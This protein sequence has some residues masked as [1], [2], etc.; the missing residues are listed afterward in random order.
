MAILL[1]LLITRTVSRLVAATISAIS[2][3]THQILAVS[4]ALDNKMQ[5]PEWL[6]TAPV[7]QAI[8]RSQATLIAMVIIYNSKFY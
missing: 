8:T 4:L 5:Q 6:P 1:A 3:T 7:L 2:V